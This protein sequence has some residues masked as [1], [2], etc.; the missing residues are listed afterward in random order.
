MAIAVVM[1]L[2]RAAATVL[3]RTVLP[4]AAG[5]VRGTA[6]ALRRLSR[7][8]ARQGAESARCA[9]PWLRRA[10]A[11]AGTDARRA[12]RWTGESLA[13]L[14]SAS[15][16]LGHDLLAVGRRLGREAGPRG[17]QVAG[18]LGRALA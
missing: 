11:E 4:S 14:A 8:L 9:A 18:A 7:T 13:A 5:M 17:R 15:R 3:A 12:W 16:P 1:E 6:R 2:G 10:T